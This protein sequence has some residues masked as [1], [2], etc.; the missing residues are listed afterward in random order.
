M[1][2]R[3]FGLFNLHHH[4]LSE[5]PRLVGE[6]VDANHGEAAKPSS[7]SRIPRGVSV[8]STSNQVTASARWEPRRKKGAVIFTSWAGGN[9]DFFLR[10]TNCV[11]PRPTH[12]FQ[13][14]P[15]DTLDLDS[16]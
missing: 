6:K 16:N 13:W 3:E 1:K 8:N 9:T 7:S 12:Y 10:D 15:A 4:L 5:A 2:N 14:W 11:S